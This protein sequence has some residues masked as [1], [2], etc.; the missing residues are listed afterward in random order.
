MKNHNKKLFWTSLIIECKDTGEKATGYKE[1]LKTDHWRQRRIDIY[2]ICDRKCQLCGKSL[3][4]PDANV[5]HKTY[6]HVG[7]ELDSDLVLLCQECH[8][9]V[10]GIETRKRRKKSWKEKSWKKKK[11]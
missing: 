1:Y 5:H 7:N 8:K 3:D 9:K 10:H 2:R 4:L 6:D 11:P